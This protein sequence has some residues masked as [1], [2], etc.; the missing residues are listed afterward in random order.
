MKA[1]LSLVLIAVAIAAVVFVVLRFPGA[2]QPS[3]PPPAPPAPASP[4]G[5]ATPT[6]AAIGYVEA[7]YQKDY[8]KAYELLSTRS[9]AAHPYN[10]FVQRAERGG[11]A[12]LDLEAAKAGEEVNGSVT[13]TVP[14][15]EDP[16]EASFTVV[17]EADGWRVVYLGGAPMFPYPEPD[18]GVGR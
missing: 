13:V 11:S 3:A 2:K 17:R 6:A 1:R 14:M 12:N 5:P 7:L 4:A 8:Q 15:V 10:D 18:A 9:Q 16:A